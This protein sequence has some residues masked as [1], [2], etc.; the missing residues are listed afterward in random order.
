[1]DDKDDND[2]D[3]TVDIPKAQAVEETVIVLLMETNS[4]ML[5]R[6]SDPLKAQGRLNA[7]TVAGLD[8]R[9][10]RLCCLDAVDA[11]V[12]SLG[13][14]WPWFIASVGSIGSVGLVWFGLVSLVRLSRW[15]GS[16][17]AD[18]PKSNQA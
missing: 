1:M 18:E 4:N 10:C 6:N 16:Q 8:C 13:L 11:V 15:S 7:T 12:V 17:R 5:V 9:R 2:D 14:W 3:D